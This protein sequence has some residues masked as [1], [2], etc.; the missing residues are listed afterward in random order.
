MLKSPVR[1]WLMS[2]GGKGLANFEKTLQG[3][4]ST[5]LRSPIYAVNM[6]SLAVCLFAA[7]NLDVEEAGWPR[8]Q[9]IKTSSWFARVVAL[10]GK[11]SPPHT[12]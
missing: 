6:A 4:V 3:G 7:V 11:C 8:M 12:P 5:P 10:V 1:H 9:V 2:H